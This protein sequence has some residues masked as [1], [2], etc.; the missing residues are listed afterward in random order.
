MSK[1]PDFVN[2]PLVDRRYEHYK[3]GIYKVIGVGKHTETEEILVCYVS[4]HFGS[5]H[6]RPLVE[7]NEPVKNWAGKRFQL[8]V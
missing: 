7:W 1:H 6:F 8:I 2:Y 5:M 3:G 4:E